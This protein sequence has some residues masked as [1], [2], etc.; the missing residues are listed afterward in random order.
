M[1]KEQLLEQLRTMSH[2]DFIDLFYLAAENRNIY[3]GEE[4]H[5]EG[6]LVLTN[7]R[8]E[9]TD[10]GEWAPWE[11]E[12]LCSTPDESWLSDSPI[13]QFGQHCG[14]PTASWAKRSTC[15]ICHGEVFGT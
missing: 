8:R 10:E 4:A 9:R 13:C 15:P 5:L 6:R 11:L 14:F 12:L 1:G 7:A 3:E 2:R